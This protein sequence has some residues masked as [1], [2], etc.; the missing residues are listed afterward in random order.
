MLFIAMCNML[1]TLPFFNLE[2]RE[3]GFPVIQTDILLFHDYF[4]FTR[5]NEIDSRKEWSIQYIFIC[6]CV[7]SQVLWLGLHASYLVWVAG[8]ARG[9]WAAQT[10]APYCW[11]ALQSSDMCHLCFSVSAAFL[12][13][14]ALDEEDLRSF[15][16]DRI[17]DLAQRT[18]Q[19]VNHTDTGNNNR[20]HCFKYYSLRWKVLIRTLR[21]SVLACPSG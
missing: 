5:L 3:D 21:Q 4:Y 11:D 8:N 14:I 6:V 9:N 16:V 7:C 1:L 19:T 2:S 18:V 15:K 12:G 20:E 10:G 17:I 13:D